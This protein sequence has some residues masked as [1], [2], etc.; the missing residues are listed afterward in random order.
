MQES[1]LYYFKSEARCQE[2]VE[3]EGST[4]A[5]LEKANGKIP[6]DSIISVFTAVSNSSYSIVLNNGYVYR[7]NAVAHH[8][9]YVLKN[10][11]IRCE[12]VIAIW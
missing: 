9:R 3:M 4:D 1:T 12:Q 2:F 8:L 6:L 7:K 11:L 5:A 10:E